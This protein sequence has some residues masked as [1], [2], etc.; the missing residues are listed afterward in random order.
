[1]AVLFAVIFPIMA[2]VEFT[3]MD[4]NSG[5]WAYSVVSSVVIAVWA[6]V[7]LRRSDI[8]AMPLVL[9][10]SAFAASATLVETLFAADPASVDVVTTFGAL[11]VLGVLAGTLSAGSRLVWSFAF[12][13]TVAAWVLAEG[14]LQGDPMDRIAVRSVVA[15]AGI[16]FTSALVSGLLDQLAVAIERHE[17]ATR[18]QNA[19]ATCSEALL[20]Q[21]DKFAIHE[22]L[23][24]L[25]EAGGPDYAYV[26]RT[27]EDDNGIGWEIIADA[28][29]RAAQPPGDW[30]AGSYD[31]ESESYQRLAT[32]R[33]VVVRTSELEGGER[34][35]YARDGI[36]SEAIVPIFIGGEF[37]GS[38]GFISYTD[39]REWTPDEL[40]TLWRASHM[41]SAYWRRQDDQEKLRASNESKDRLLASVSHEI[42]TPLTAIVGLSEE[43]VSSRAEMTD[44]DLDEL[45]GIIAA[46]SRDLADLVEDLLVGARADS[47]NLS[48][49]PGWIDLRGEVDKV[50]AGVRES[51]PSAKLIAVMGEDVKAWA[52]PLRCRQVVRNLL[53]NA[54][55]YGG[56]RVAVVV[57]S[58][59]EHAQVLVID[60]GLGVRPDESEMIFERYYRSDESP[61]QPG[62]V[63]IGLSVSRQLAELMD[64]KLTYVSTSGDSRFEFTIPATAPI[65]LENVSL[66]IPAVSA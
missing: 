66:E 15:V 52:D 48:I 1:V 39:E 8:D 58:D 35:I 59:D 14:L 3:S 10:T 54:I 31:P 47:G 22:A 6:L 29:R 43:I 42:R 36:R 64:G 13:A 16:V 44:A 18:L 34:E 2:V 4:R 20:I 62:S 7:L 53:T 46:Q 5:L 11:M 23:K 9:A 28:H 41:I 21:T 40:N 45:S 56:D 50:V 25:L 63:G 12:G 26:D 65:E 17:H 57:Q 38:I 30:M 55:K 49:R 61:T 51:N 33:S 37:R 60:D 24:A 19:I 32:G 27:I